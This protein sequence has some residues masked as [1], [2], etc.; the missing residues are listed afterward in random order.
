MALAT[1]VRRAAIARRTGSS[2]TTRLAPLP[3]GNPA[4]LVDPGAEPVN[5]PIG[6]V[7]RI[8]AGAKRIRP[9]T[10]ATLHASGLMGPSVQHGRKS[11]T[12]PWRDSIG[13]DERH[14]RSQHAV[15]PTKGSCR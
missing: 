7:R 3:A 9:L 15:R 6:D 8:A 4:P 5:E 10:I 12:A 1:A 11:S 2:L 14:H 13:D